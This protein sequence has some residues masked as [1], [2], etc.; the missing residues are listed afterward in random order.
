MYRLKRIVTE[1]MHRNAIT[2]NQ[3]KKLGR[4]RDTHDYDLLTRSLFL[5]QQHD[6]CMA[7]GGV[8]NRPFDWLANCLAALE[9][10]S[11]GEGAEERPRQ[12]AREGEAV[13]QQK[14]G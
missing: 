7:G 5:E 8:G 13:T 3:P 9:S 1:E 11:L 12:P 6:P 2:R 4:V 14:V 10:V